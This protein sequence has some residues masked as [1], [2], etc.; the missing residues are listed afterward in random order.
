MSFPI[1]FP[2]D[3][4]VGELY[5]NGIQ[6]YIWDGLVWRLVRTSAVG[7]TGPTGPQGADSTVPGPTGPLGPTGPTGA[8][9]DV[10]G[11]TGP[12]GPAG[13]F[14]ITS[15]TTYTP[16][17]GASV[18]NPTLGNGSITGRYVN[19]GAT[20]IGEVRIVA[21]VTGFDRGE[22]IYTISLPTLAV[23]ENLQ[24]VGQV[25]MRDEGPGITYVGTAAFASN[26]NDRVQLF[27]HSQAASF[28][29]AVA[30][31]HN[32]PFLFGANDRILLQLLYE[33][34]LS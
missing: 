4:E 7:P 18:T 31:T 19:I 28:D 26:Q 30:A 8:D 3:P 23:F 27:L 5:T 24:P 13:S 29:E 12:T 33:S 1:D 15:W 10:V 9:S 34:D 14:S 6:T 20:I 2:E 25:F 21:G 32:T 11:P 16:L 17:W 22:G